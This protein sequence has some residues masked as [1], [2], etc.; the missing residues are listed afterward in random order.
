MFPPILRTA[1]PRFL[2][3]FTTAACRPNDF[4]LYL[5]THRPAVANDAEFI[6]KIVRAV[7]AGVTA[8]QLRDS[9]ADRSALERTALW[10]KPLLSWYGVSLI[11]NNDVLMAEKV[12]ADGVHLGASDTPVADARRRLGPDAIIGLTVNTLEQALSAAHLDVTYLSPTVLFHSLRTKPGYPSE[13]LWGTERLRVLRGSV[14]QR[15]VPIGGINLHNLKEVSNVL[16]IGARGDGVAMVG[17]LWRGEDPAV[18]ARI[19]RQIL[20]GEGVC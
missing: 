6:Y 2:R 12:G 4:R 19:A 5:V 9:Y 18:V 8:I 15:L 1:T 20:D 14:S 7:Q 10:I 13:H 16:Q 11:I 3:P 17:D